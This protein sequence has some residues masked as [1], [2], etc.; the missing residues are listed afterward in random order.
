[1]SE[2]LMA[3]LIYGCVIGYLLAQVVLLKQQIRKLKKEK[4]GEK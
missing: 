4:K 2:N 1:M 3:F